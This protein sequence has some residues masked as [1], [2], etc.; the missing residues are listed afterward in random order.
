MIEYDKWA[1]RELIVYLKDS[2]L[3]EYYNI[4][5]DA[6]EQYSYGEGNLEWLRDFYKEFYWIIF[7]CPFNDLPMEVNHMYRAVVSWRLKRGT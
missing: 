6:L 2:D 4:L 7:V 5:I 3:P 1:I